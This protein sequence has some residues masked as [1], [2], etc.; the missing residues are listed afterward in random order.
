MNDSRELAKIAKISKIAKTSERPDQGGIKPKSSM[1]LGLALCAF[2][3][4]FNDSQFH[5]SRFQ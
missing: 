5:D 1:N 4:D 2:A 3:R